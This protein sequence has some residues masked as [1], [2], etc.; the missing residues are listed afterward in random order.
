MGLLIKG[1][2]HDQGYD[3]RATGGR[4]VREETQFRNWVTAD[5]APGPSGEGGFAAETGRY[6]LYICMACPWAHRTLI[7]RRL[8]GLEEM[9][10]VS[11]VNAYL[12]TGGWTFDADGNNQ[13]HLYQSGHLYEIYL[14]ARPDYSGRVTVPVLWDRK[15]ETIVNNESAEIIR[16]LNDAFNGLGAKGGD[17]YP[18]SLRA[19]I[20]DLN[21]YIYPN[22]NN[23]VYRAGFATTQRAYEEAWHDV[24]SALD[25]IETRLETRRYLTGDSLTEADIRLFP[26][27]IRFDAVYYSHFKCN[28]QRI[29]DFPNLHGYVR[30]IY[31]QPGVAD[32]VDLDLIKRHY[33]TSHT[34]INP[35]GIVPLGP[36]LDFS[37]P[38]GRDKVGRGVN[39]ES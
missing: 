9:I 12:G 28:R 15:R 1:V 31:Q 18:E 34:A 16:M 35:T 3:T 17:Y 21:G 11:E 27:L 37:T 7:M 13:D 38:H 39:G 19:E 8:K 5:G 2:W 23:G 6:H 33:Y 30:D 32:T 29:E 22:L 36:S 10:G 20:D 4:F 14:R 26:T 25:T 24:F